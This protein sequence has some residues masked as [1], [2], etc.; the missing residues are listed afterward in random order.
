MSMEA[1]YS[2]VRSADLDPDLR[3]ALSQVRG[4]D[5]IV[6]LAASRGL[7]FTA[8]ELAP[9]VS[10]LRFLADL[11]QDS[12]L[13]DQVARAATPS[14]VLDLARARGYSFSESELGH[15]SIEAARDHELSDDDLR[16]I[17]GGAGAL[18]VGLSIQVQTSVARQSPQTDFGTVLSRGMS[19][20]ADATLSAGQ[21]AAPF[22]PGGAVLS[23][24]IS[25]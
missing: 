22:I 5:A 8:E 20:G 7:Q 25:G 16:G 11:G 6:Q 17:A 1:V 24:A 13:R 21:L 2:F 12:D 3:R 19:R 9:V 14:A 23:A 18:D 4:T 15:V 10:L